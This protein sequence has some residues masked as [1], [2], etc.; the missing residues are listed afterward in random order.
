M[1]EKC[2]VKA[3]ELGH[4]HLDIIVVDDGLTMYLC[5][6][7]GCRASIM[8]ST[9]NGKESCAGS[10]LTHTCGKYNSHNDVS[11]KGVTHKDVTKLN[12]KEYK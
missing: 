3:K 12:L 6:K 9:H 4:K 11:M 5:N 7:S 8:V 10:A 2:L 1:L